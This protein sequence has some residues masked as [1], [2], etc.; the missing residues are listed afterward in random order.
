[1]HKQSIILLFCAF[2]LAFS[3]CATQH[4]KVRL[5]GA[6]EATV[7]E[8]FGKSLI[9]AEGVVSAQRISTSIVPDYPQACH[10]L[11]DATVKDIESFQ[12][13][14]AITENVRKVLRA[15]GDISLENQ[16]FSYSRDEIAL[17]LGLRAGQATAGEI[18]FVIDRE[19]ARDREMSG[20]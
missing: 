15:G 2:I 10:I 5:D 16:N 9:A 8:V 18:Q 14:T 3:G 4:L 19:L 13:Q 20:W 1:M 7:A 12:L 6:N 11:W 17:L